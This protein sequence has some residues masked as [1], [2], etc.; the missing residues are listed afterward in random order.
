[1][2]R[3][4]E[5]GYEILSAIDFLRDAADVI[6]AHHERWDGTGYPR[7]IKGED[8]PIGA[9]IFAVVDAYNAMT[10]HRPY[11]KAQPHRHAVEEIVRNSGSQFDPTVVRAFLEAER[12]GLLESRD[13]QRGN[14]IAGSGKG[15]RVP[16][17]ED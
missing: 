3:H 8:I 9:R 1:M 12:R 5:L 6:R 7:G 4:P 15:E 10:S 13:G 2:K 17:S 14:A 11:R 16:V